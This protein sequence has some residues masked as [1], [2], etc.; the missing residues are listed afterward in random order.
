MF[1]EWWRTANNMLSVSGERKETDDRALFWQQEM[2]ANGMPLVIM[3][4]T[5]N[6][7][8]IML[9]G[10]ESSDPCKPVRCRYC[11][12]GLSY[13]ALSGAAFGN[14]GRHEVWCFDKDKWIYSEHDDRMIAAKRAVE[15][16]KFVEA[17]LGLG[18]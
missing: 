13:E 11:E 18:K 8:I 1:E 10:D 16:E 9:V 4:G 6:K 7:D 14:I 12:H 2:A 15:K 5:P 17:Q 3:F